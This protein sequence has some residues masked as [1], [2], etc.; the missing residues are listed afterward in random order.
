M[1]HPFLKNNY[2][3]N[4]KIS[5]KNLYADQLYNLIAENGDYEEM[6]ML[7][8]ELLGIC[9]M[10]LGLEYHYAN[11]KTHNSMFCL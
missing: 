5:K 1:N 2:K 4:Q 3:K 7:E 10:L 6:R 9:D 11:F 8:L